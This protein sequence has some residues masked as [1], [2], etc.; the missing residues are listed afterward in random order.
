[1]SLITLGTG[2]S[3]SAPDLKSFRMMVDDMPVNVMTCTLDG[4]II[5][6]LNKAALN[7]L[8]KIEHALPIPASKVL[9][10]SIDVFHANPSHQRTMLKDMANLPHR[11]V[12]EIGGEYLDLTITP[13]K[14]PDGRYLCPLVTWSLV[15]EK[16][17]ADAEVNRQRSMLD[18]MPV[19]AMMCEVKDFKITY[20]NKTSLDTLK[21]LEQYLPITAAE[22]VG[23]SIDVFHKNPGHQRSMLSNPNNLPH[24]TK[25]KV[26]PETLDLR[27]SAVMDRKGN[28]T[29]ALLTWSVV[30]RNVKMAD[31]FE[32]DVKNLVDNVASS[33]TE[34]QATSQSMAA[35]AEEANTQAA[36]VS[37]ATEELSASAKE[38]GRQVA[39]S[40]SISA[41]GVETV[42]RSDAQVKGLADAANRI[43]QVVELIN[44]I[45]SQTN[46]LALNATIEAA[47]AGDAGKGFAV[48]A[49]EV[50]TL[51]TQTAKATEEIGSQIKEMQDATGIAVKA[52]DEISV[53]I[54]RINENSTAISAAVEEQ[55]AALSEVTSNIAGVSQASSETGHA[56]AET[57]S[58]AG[59]LSE[60]SE[61]LTRQV[62]EFLEKVR[63]L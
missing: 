57:L 30:T 4:F 7:T 19:N 8:K 43:G 10:S 28:Y 6:Y 48:V 18:Q 37:A 59:G 47:R 32:T 54:S 15:T 60:L 61:T 35:A 62:T 39:D 26:G 55:N 42:K 33:A 38:I 40:A 16:V 5:N 29:Y 2:K 45:A 49:N 1:M 14:R 58:A 34:L 24:Q 13:L 41:D 25:I 27:V 36:T 21:G 46:L 52:I 9:G 22:L 53:V 63:A 17:E 31:D 51:A 20:A 56:A 50:K 11:A 23:S 12:I 3:V 44:D